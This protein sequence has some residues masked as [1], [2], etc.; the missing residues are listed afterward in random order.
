MSAAIFTTITGADWRRALGH[1]RARR[2][3]MGA[4]V[5]AFLR[6]RGRASVAGKGLSAA[7]RAAQQSIC[8]GGV[9]TVG[10]KSGETP[11]PADNCAPR[12]DVLTSS[13]TNPTKEAA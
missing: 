12:G 7:H 11:A 5:E 13:A 2:A 3:G 9:Q 1:S 4:R 6:G 8:P 10:P